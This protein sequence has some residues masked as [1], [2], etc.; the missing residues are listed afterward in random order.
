MKFL[1]NHTS[2]TFAIASLQG[3]KQKQ[4]HLRRG[5]GDKNM[6]KTKALLVLSLVA[7]TPMIGQTWNTTGNAVTSGQ[8]LGATNNTSL[9]FITNNTVRFKIEPD[10]KLKCYD[11][12]GT[13]NRLVQ[14]NNLGVLSSFPMAT[15]STVLCGDGIWRA[16]SAIAGT[17]WTSSG[18]HLFSANTGSVGIG[19]NPSTITSPAKLNVQGD[20]EKVSLLS[21]S[22]HSSDL[23]INSIIK[24]NRDGAIALAVQSDKSILDVPTGVVHPWMP[25]TITGT[26]KIQFSTVSA[27]G[28]G[29]GKGN[30]SEIFSVKAVVNPISNYNYNGGVGSPSSYSLFEDGSVSINSNNYQLPLGYYLAV[31]GKVICEELVVK[32]RANWPDYVFSKDYKL[33]DLNE[34]ET[35]IAANKHLPN[36]PSAQ[37]V[38]AKGFETGEIIKLQMEKIE[39]LSLYLIQQNKVLAAQQMQIEKQA[40]KALEQAKRLEVLE[41]KMK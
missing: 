32:L 6:K 1:I 37:E 29:T 2:Y 25:L 15:A 13:G 20:L 5:Y 27:T 14:A 7:I 22:N 23:K 21:Y 40:A 36:I 11:L 33:K 35:Y 26:G 18:N 8:V 34:L 19:V 39:E 31:N 41:A 10:G 16:P 9:F 4:K 24:V 3:S 28:A 38:A 30:P 12:V 17:Q